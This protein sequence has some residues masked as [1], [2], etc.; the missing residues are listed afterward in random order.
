M[1]ADK[2]PLVNGD[3][4]ETHFP[5][6]AGVAAGGA[7]QCDSLARIA[8]AMELYAV[9]ATFRAVAPSN[10]RESAWRAMRAL[11]QGIEGDACGPQDVV[12]R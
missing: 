8:R 1:S 11:V 2:E 9:T 3:A 10:V 5:P 7:V 12:R 4:R 6:L